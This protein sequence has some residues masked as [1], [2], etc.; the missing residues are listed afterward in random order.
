MSEDENQ[1]TDSIQ[2]EHLLLKCLELKKQGL[3]DDETIQKAFREAT[4]IHNFLNKLVEHVK[5]E[6]N[7][8]SIRDFFNKTT[9]ILP[10]SKFFI[11]MRDD[12][13]KERFLIKIQE[14][15][16][17]QNKTPDTSSTALKKYLIRVDGVEHNNEGTTFKIT[18]LKNAQNI[19]EKG[20]KRRTSKKS[21]EKSP[22]KMSKRQLHK[23]LKTMKLK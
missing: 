11:S 7:K 10:E 12:K 3:I 1:D 21:I 22:G 5:D 9:I 20:G 6:Q 19:V 13:F 2:G 4:N 14:A 17:K 15:L 8:I 23:L 18:V 16:D